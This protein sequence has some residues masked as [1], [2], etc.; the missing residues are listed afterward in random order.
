MAGSSELT[1][2]IMGRAVGRIFFKRKSLPGAGLV[3]SLTNLF[4]K[5]GDAEIF[6]R[7]GEICRFTQSYLPRSPNGSFGVGVEEMNSSSIDHQGSGF[8]WGHI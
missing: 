5:A 3:I 1:S 4:G 6:I 2:V 8:S 7:F